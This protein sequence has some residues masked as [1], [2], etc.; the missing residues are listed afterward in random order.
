M[1][2]SG[3]YAL[4]IEDGKLT[5]INAASGLNSIRFEFKYGSGLLN[6]IPNMPEPEEGWEDIESEPEF[7]GFDY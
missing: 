1:S 3:Q 7:P 6:L 4:T 5:A 2:L